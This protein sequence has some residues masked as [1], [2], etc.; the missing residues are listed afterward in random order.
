MVASMLNGELPDIAP[1]EGTPIPMDDKEIRQELKKKNNMLT[2]L[3]AQRVN[4]EPDYEDAADYVRPDMYWREGEQPSDKHKTRS[5]IINETPTIALRTASA[6]LHGGATGPSRPW[7]NLQ[8]P[9]PDVNKQQ[10]VKAWL[11]EVE[12]RIRNVLLRSNVYKVLPKLYSSLVLF[13]VG[14]VVVTDDRDDVIRFHHRTMGTFWINNDER[15]IVRTYVEQQFFTVAN[16]VKTFGIENVSESVRRKY[17]DSNGG[18]QESI[19]VAWCIEPNDEYKPNSPLAKHKKYRSTWW[20]VGKQDNRGLLSISG[21]DMFRVLV[22]RWDTNGD[23]PYGIGPGVMSVP[24]YKAMNLLEKQRSVAHELQ[25]KPP[26]VASPTLEGEPKSLIPGGVTYTDDKDGF[27]TAFNVS[28]DEGGTTAELREIEDR[29]R[30]MFFEDLF[31]MVANIDKSNITATEIQARQQERMMVLGPVLGGL[32]DELLDPLIDLV[33][34]AMERRDMI[35]PAPDELVGV[36]L[37]I[38]Y[39][40]ILAQAQ[41][42]SDVTLT[43]RWLESVNRLYQLTQDQEVL[44]NV[45]IDKTIEE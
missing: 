4:K 38:E 2:A 23:D 24:A 37:K 1:Y 43:D 16:L 6:G 29:I 35:P 32:D 31:L 5:K 42:A 25:I 20:E 28:L 39:I 44:D 3:K 9:D 19:K 34:D 11:A 13:G 36:K 17:K 26:M 45:E 18:S 41:K 27:R 15:G 30:R 8:H 12:D 10:T 21:Y 7:F 14:A 22:P 33:Y 40:S